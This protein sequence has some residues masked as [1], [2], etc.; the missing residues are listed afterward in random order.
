MSFNRWQIESDTRIAKVVVSLPAAVAGRRR[1]AAF[2]LKGPILLCFVRDYAG[3]AVL[4]LC[5]RVSSAPRYTKNC[6]IRQVFV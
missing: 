3:V 6:R 1:V 2:S 5:V 4:D